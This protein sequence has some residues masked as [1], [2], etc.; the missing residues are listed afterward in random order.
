MAA[1]PTTAMPIPMP[2][3]A[4]VASPAAGVSVDAAALV[5][6]E[7]VADEVLLAEVEDEASVL[8]A[9]AVVEGVYELG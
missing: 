6:A 1:T 5:V 7:A 4:V 8:S 3:L 2:I 9:A